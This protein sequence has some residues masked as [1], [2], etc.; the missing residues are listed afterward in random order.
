M[1]AG[2]P[3][4]KLEPQVHSSLESPAG[5]FSAAISND[6]ARS[7]GLA[8]NAA[9]FSPAPICMNCQSRA[10]ILRS[11]L[12]VVAVISAF[13]CAAAFNP[14]EAREISRGRLLELSEEGCTDHMLYEGSDFSYH[15]V[16]DSRPDRRRSYKIRTDVMPVRET[17]HVGED[18]YVLHPW[19][20]EGKPFGS[21]T[22]E[23]PRE[24]Q[25]ADEW[26]AKEPLTG[27]LPAEV[28]R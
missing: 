13:G 24:E 12:S 18:S 7:G 28:D 23:L 2:H 8:Y 21:R 5:R 6:I 22:E 16:Y 14:K 4:I 25:A 9:P 10:L 20:I 3:K 11:L 1:R 27:E 17:F 26:S 19:V 15:Y